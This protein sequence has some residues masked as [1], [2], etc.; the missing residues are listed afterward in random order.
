M[1]LLLPLLVTAPSRAQ[2]QFPSQPLVIPM[3]SQPTPPTVIRRRPEL[4]TSKPTA[5]FAVTLRT[6]LLQ[7]FVN[8]QTTSTD[9]VVTQVMEADVRGVQTTTTNIALT[10]SRS[11]DV[12]RLDLLA[13]GTVC[14]NTVG[15]TPQARVAT[16][17]NHTFSIRKP[18]YFDGRQFLTKKAF[19]NV[20]VKQVPQSVNTVATGVPLIGQIGDRI[21]WREVYRRMPTSDAIVVRK[22]ADDVL[23]KVN[24]GIDKE[25]A[26]LNQSWANLRRSV[27]QT[28][29]GDRIDWKAVSAE[30]SFAVN[31]RNSAVDLPAK[32]TLHSPLDDSEVASVV[33]ADAAINRWLAVQP[34]NG[35][36]IPDAALQH[37]FTSVWS[38]ENKVAAALHE[39]QNPDLLTSEPL[40][41]SLRLADES[42]VTMGF[43]YGE[44]ELR[45]RYQIL[46]KTGVAGQ[47]QQMNVRVRGRGESDGRWSLLLTD[48]SVDPADKS[49]PADSWTTLVR[50]QAAQMTTLIPPTILP[51]TIDLPRLHEKLPKVQLHRIQTDSGWLRVSLR[52][53]NADELMTRRSQ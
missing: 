10:P 6:D 9:N 16:A 52:R 14:S 8:R 46:P 32:Q 50:N 47:M 15:F 28:Y 37:L 26:K 40:M 39:L 3:E 45:L 27:E 49:E 30:N 2:I 31:A 29:S 18:V 48:V 34:I 17:G 21:A 42:P 36:T 19:G 41:F 25:L 20:K 53:I 1:S 35:I 12:A 33:V 43:D 38:T 23:P 11:D 7:E 4:P 22:V 13:T 5:G 24:D 44:L 51:R